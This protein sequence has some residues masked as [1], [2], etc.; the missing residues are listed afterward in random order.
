MHRHIQGVY[1]I[2]TSG[3]NNSMVYLLSREKRKLKQHWVALF[4]FLH[5]S[6]E[7]VF[8]DESQTEQVWD[9]LECDV[10]VSTDVN[11]VL[12]QNSKGRIYM[13]LWK[14]HIYNLFIISHSSNYMKA[15]IEDICQNECIKILTIHK[16]KNTVLT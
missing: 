12:F 11:G 10:R 2:L 8:N 1:G 14:L 7:T 5:I 9:A 16:N 13:D 15:I 6:L 4:F 3:K